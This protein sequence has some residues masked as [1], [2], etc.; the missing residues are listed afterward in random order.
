LAV[1]ISLGLTSPPAEAIETLLASQQSANTNPTRL[2]SDALAALEKFI[3][4]KRQELN[5]PGVGVAIVQEDRVIFAKGFGWRNVEEGL[6]VTPN[7]LFAI[8]SCTK[9][10]TAVTVLMSAEEGKLA[11][12]D[13][14]KKYLPYFKLSDPE[15]DSKITIGDLLC[16]RSGLGRTDLAWYMGQLRSEEVIRV[17]GVAK[18]TAKFGEKLQY[19]N[20]MYLV[21]GEIVG[22]VHRK[23]WGQVVAERIFR[24]LGMRSSNVS[25][26]EMQCT[27]DY[28][29]GYTFNPET[30]QTIPLPMK[31]LSHIAPA[32]AINSSVKDMAQWIRLMLNGGILEG[33]RLLSD[34]SF[35]ELWVE[36]GKLMGTTGYGYGWALSEWNGHRVA[37][38]GG[39]ID[40]FTAHV[41]LMPGKKLGVV[42]LSNASGTP[43]PGIITKAIWEHLIKIPQKPPQSPPP[44]SAYV[45][46]VDPASEAGTY[47][48]STVKMDLVIAFKNGK[49]TITPTGQPEMPL[50]PMGGRRYRIGPPAPPD[51]FITFRP[52]QDNPQET[53]LLLEQSGMKFIGKKPAAFVAP[54]SIEELMQKVL[55]AAGGEA[56]LRKHKTLVMTFDAELENQGLTGE[57]IMKMQAPNAYEKRVMLRTLGKKLATIRDF[58]DGVRGGDELGS[59]ITLPKEGN[60]LADAAIQGEFYP[61]L[62]WRKLFKRITIKKMDKIE[63]EEV[64]VVEKIPEKGSALTDY[65]STKSSLTLKRE[66]PGPVTTTFRD[67]RAVD[68][69]MIPFTMIQEIPGQGN[70]RLKVREV[71]FNMRIPPATFRPRERKS[72]TRPDWWY[73]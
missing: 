45:P 16:H 3:E 14:P 29:R 60:A 68:G 9:A 34:G 39:A 27:I 32:G 50:E 26:R 25:I 44:L 30:K 18:P 5:V 70:T 43:L 64:Y 11:L 73:L 37:E 46:S 1:L 33:K 51:V 12:T 19:Q 66:G 57:V 2:P 6:P 40:G 67:Y 69:V 61:E 36:R 58:F 28:A 71:R 20:V 23:P 35:R 48:L 47:H 13:S 72:V 17:A 56:N 24:P 52:S 53:E 8:G 55:V 21:A 65:I 42:I 38:H 63:E 41:A 10:F 31:D 62:H 54:L 59:S 7:T 4:E 22:K 15:A 49:L